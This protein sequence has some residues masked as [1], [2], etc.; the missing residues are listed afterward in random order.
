M[1]SLYMDLLRNPDI[2]YVNIINSKY[3][4]NYKKLINSDKSV[5]QNFIDMIKNDYP[6]T[7][8]KN[9]TKQ[10]CSILKKLLSIVNTNSDKI[11]ILESTASSYFYDKTPCSLYN[12]YSENKGKKGQK[13]Q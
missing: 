6:A 8:D 3:S 2:Q 10:V 13:W 11:K 7:N 1:K 4:D 9:V 12:T 5:F